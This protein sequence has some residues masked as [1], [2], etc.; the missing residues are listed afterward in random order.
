MS[1]DERPA[2]GHHEGVRGLVARIAEHH[3]EA[4]RKHEEDELTETVDEAAFDLGADIAHPGAG[5]GPVGYDVETDLGR[6]KEPP[7]LRP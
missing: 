3:W 1:H 6:E 5:H 7:E 2:D 4:V